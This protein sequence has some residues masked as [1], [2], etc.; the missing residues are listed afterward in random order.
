MKPACF[1][2]DRN[3][4]SVFTS[5]SSNQPFLMLKEKSWFIIRGFSKT[6]KFIWR[7][8]QMRNFNCSA[9]E[10]TEVNFKTLCCLFT[11]YWWRFFFAH[12]RWSK[13]FRCR[14][15]SLEWAENSVVCS[16]EVSL[17]IISFKHLFGFP[18]WNF[19]RPRVNRR[20]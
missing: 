12:G 18:V 10:V 1:S 15:K 7:H 20:G 9:V 13:V 3:F 17:R 11:F 8:F 14:F 2:T 6:I 5:C 4:L 19:G 16:L